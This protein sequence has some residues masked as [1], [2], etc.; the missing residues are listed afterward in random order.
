M[1][2]AT[3]CYQLLGKVL[4]CKGKQSVHCSGGVLIVGARN[5]GVKSSDR[6]G[7]KPLTVKFLQRRC[8]RKPKRAS[9]SNA[10]ATVCFF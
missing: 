5:T 2:K 1:P 8:L 3:Q 6:S 10:A 4:S 7:P 9:P